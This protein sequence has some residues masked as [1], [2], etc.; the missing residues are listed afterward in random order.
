MSFCLLVQVLSLLVFLLI[1]TWCRYFSF[2]V[3]DPQFTKSK[4]KNSSRY[5]S[6]AF[7]QPMYNSIYWYV[8]KA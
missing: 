5:P 1:S 2:F 4:S 8:Y 3:L 7:A 6:L